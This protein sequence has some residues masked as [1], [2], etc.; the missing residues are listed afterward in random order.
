MKHRFIA[1]H[2]PLRLAVKKACRAVCSSPSGYFKSLKKPFA[3][4]DR[5]ETEVL[6]AFY[7][8]KGLYGYRK[9]SHHLAKIGISCSV[10][11]ARR[12]MSKQ[13]LKAKPASSFKPQTTNSAHKRPFSQRVFKAE[14]TA[15]TAL[16]QVWGGDI[17]YLKACGGKFLYLAMFLDFCSRRIV[18]WDLSHNLSSQVV[19]RA[20]DR[21]LKTRSVTKGLIVHSDRGGQY[22]AREVRENLKKCGFVQSMSRKGNCYDNAYCESWFSLLKRELGHKVYSSINEAREEIFEW[23]EGWYNTHRLHSALDYKSPLEFEKMMENTP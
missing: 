11:Q 16:N 23:I 1:K 6:S 17:T 12:I 19:L 8:H 5:I 21:A 18:G 9:I 13:G 7:A 15:V 2:K 3:S 4:L 14:E 10:D 22:T 20:F